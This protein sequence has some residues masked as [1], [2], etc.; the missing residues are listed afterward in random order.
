MTGQTFPVGGWGNRVIAVPRPR[1]KA[2]L[3]RL[4]SRGSFTAYSATPWIDTPQERSSD[5]ALHFQTWGRSWHPFVLPARY[6]H[7]EVD[8]AGHNGVARWQL[9]RV[10][11]EDVQ[12]LPASVAGHGTR[13]L[14][15]KGGPLEMRFEYADHRGG[16]AFRHHAFES[17][18]PLDVETT[19]TSRGTVRIGGPGYLW[20][21]SAPAAAWTLRAV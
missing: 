11:P 3:L 14:A 13:L 1:G 21:H 16:L 19:G 12:P 2:A 8:K 6:T 10:P 5:A 9:G 15:W 7:L 20:I 18:E 4:R 17:G